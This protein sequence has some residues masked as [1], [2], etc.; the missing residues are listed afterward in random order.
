MG[1]FWPLFLQIFFSLI[2]LFSLFGT[3][4]RCIL[5]LLV[6]AHQSLRRI[7]P[8]TSTLF[9]SKHF[10]LTRFV[11]Q[12]LVSYTH[13][14]SIFSKMFG[15]HG[16]SKRRRVAFQLIK[17]LW[18]YISNSLKFHCNYNLEDRP[19]TFYRFQ[20]LWSAILV[21]WCSKIEKILVKMHPVTES[22]CHCFQ[23]V[24]LSSYEYTASFACSNK[25]SFQI[26]ND[27]MCLHQNSSKWKES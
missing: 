15:R 10:S 25:I 4:I 24:P 18:L 6:L 2:S 11:S 19:S 21:F 16:S 12:F 5:C 9:L 23:M 7:C 13:S 26:F 22:S 1:N 17:I 27:N 14:F 3:L 8:L 20:I